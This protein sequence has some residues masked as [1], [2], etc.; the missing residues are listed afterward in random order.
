MASREPV[1]LRCLSAMDTPRTLLQ[2]L[3]DQAH[4]LEHRPALWSRLGRT[5]VPT[6]WRDLALRVKRLALGLQALGF[7][8][9]DTLPI[10]SSSREEAW[11]AC[12]AAMALGGV[13]VS[14]APHWSV[15]QVA[16]R[17]EHCQARCCVVEDAARLVT[18]LAVRTRVPRVRHLVVL[19]PP[20][21]SLP[22]AVRGYADLQAL[23]AST[24][25]APYWEAVNALRPE[26][27]ATLVSLSSPADAPRAVML[28]HR[29]LV[30]TAERLARATH[31]HL[32]GEDEVVLAHQPLSHLAGQ[33]FGLSVPL[34]VGGQVY[35]ARSP[36]SLARD[37][38]DVRPTLFFGEPRVW[39]AFKERIEAAVEG[40]TPGQRRALDWARKATAE[41]N[42]L[43]LAHERAPLLLE[44][45]YQLARRTV[46]PPLVEELGFGRARFLATGGAPVR[47]EVLDFFASLDLVPR[48]IHGRAEGGGPLALNTL[49]ATRLGSQGRPL[50]GV[51]A[52]IA[53][54]GELLVRG[55]GVCLG[56]YR[57]PAATARL[58]ADGWLH[59]GDVGALD[60]EGFVHLTG[61]TREGLESA[62]TRE[63]RA[64]RAR[65]A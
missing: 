27:L 53:G 22:E 15:E 11:V 34:L 4:R 17:V 35:F 57:E 12:L 61:R 7:R 52:R 56:Y 62:E 21:A 8:P 33:L 2:A 50:M 42:A 38:R 9:G 65:G 32:A 26:A 6:S 23:G 18:G 45:Q 30:W 63:P 54:D 1:S 36:E 31:A 28:S 25:D 64:P 39:T 37:L 59:T 44:S 16:S 10:L 19:D 3:H 48:E 51:E 20:E 29:N 60:A 46:F 5:Y 43:V 13:P 58:L 14:L 40:Q 49:E 24:P 55:G 47:R 41:R